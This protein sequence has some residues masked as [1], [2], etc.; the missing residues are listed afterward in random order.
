MFLDTIN[1]NP[2]FFLGVSMCPLYMIAKQASVCL[3]KNCGII[4]DYPFSF[5]CKLEFSN[6]RNNYH[7]IYVSR[8]RLFHPIN[9]IKVTNVYPV[10]KDL[11]CIYIYIYRVNSCPV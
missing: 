11:G 10:Y 1:A 2:R 3:E 9:V 4:L 5:F 6:L 8:E 7:N